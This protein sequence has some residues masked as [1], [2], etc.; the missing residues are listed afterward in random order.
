MTEDCLFCKIVNGEIPSD[1]LYE[2]KEVI[3]F[4]DIKPISRGHALYVPKKHI[5][6]LY[7]LKEEEMSFMKKLPAIAQKLKEATGATG[8][9]LIQN[10]G[11]D[12]GQ[13]IFHLHFHLIPR[14]NDDG[15]TVLPPR[16]EFDRAVAE[17]LKNKFA[18]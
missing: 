2:D 1:I 7:E 11:T 13:V 9:N 3:V 14:Q 16:L 10:N 17:E 15:L 8:L 12:A 4:L 18:V 6:D 5:A